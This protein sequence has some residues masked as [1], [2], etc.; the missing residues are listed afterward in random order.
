MAIVQTVSG[1]FKH[2]QLLDL[3]TM[4]K[5]LRDHTE[6]CLEPNTLLDITSVYE[7][8]QLELAKD[9]KF[10]YMLPEDGDGIFGIN[11]MHR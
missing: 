10:A 11:L 6:S 2:E 9:S 1:T 4:A 8:R 5:N 7:Q 3:S